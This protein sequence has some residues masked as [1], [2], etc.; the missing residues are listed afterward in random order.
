[1]HDRIG[2]DFFQRRR[3]VAAVLQIA[4]DEFGGGVHSPAVPLGEVVEDGDRVALFDKLRD[5]V[6]PYIAGAAGDEDFHVAAKKA[7]HVC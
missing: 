2:A 5:A 1:M 3:D 7:G 4:D 6:A